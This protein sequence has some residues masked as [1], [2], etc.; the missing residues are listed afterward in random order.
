M[1]LLLEHGEDPTADDNYAIRLS[2]QMG[3]VEVVKLLLEYG[4]DP[5]ADDNYAI[6]FSSNGRVEVVSSL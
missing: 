5:T 1:K 2:S 4:A 6:R 3:H